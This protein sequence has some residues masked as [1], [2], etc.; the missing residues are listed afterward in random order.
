MKLLIFLSLT[1]MLASANAFS[2]E[3]T[4]EKWVKISAEQCAVSMAMDNAGTVY[5]CHVDADPEFKGQSTTF[6]DSV[7]FAMKNGCGIVLT[8]NGNAQDY[9]IDVRSVCQKGVPGPRIGYD[10][11]LLFIGSYLGSFID[12]AEIGHPNSY[13]VLVSE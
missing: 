5:Q 10:R 1:A 11:A 9:D 2:A 3:K 6:T 8:I 12:H 4:S 7:P 13:Q